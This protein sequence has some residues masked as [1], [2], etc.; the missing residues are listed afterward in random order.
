MQD[1]R[2]E[3]ILEAV[4]ALSEEQRQRLLRRLM[5]EYGLPVQES[6]PL[7]FETAQLDGPADYVVIF[8]GGSQGN[9][10]AAYGSYH[11]TRTVDERSRLV[12]LDF[13]REMTNNEAEYQTLI[14]A[15]EGLIGRIEAAGRDPGTFTVEVRGDSALVL[16]QVEGTWKAKDDRMRGL[17]NRV[18]ELLACFKA[19]R[20]VLQGREESVRL[21]GH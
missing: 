18:R 3:R 11:L 15:L 21:L 19:H 20:L 13:E 12:R 7:A 6:F 9:P 4:S 5:K 8:D 17:R 10:G 14:A 2:V 16:H 1:E